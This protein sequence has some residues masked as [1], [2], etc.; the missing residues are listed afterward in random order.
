MPPPRNIIKKFSREPKLQNV[1]SP[2]FIHRLD[3]QKMKK[4]ASKTLV[5]SISSRQI[6]TL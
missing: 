5:F 1:H 4:L 2:V 3:S 6:N